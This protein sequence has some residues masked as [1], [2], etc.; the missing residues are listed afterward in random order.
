MSKRSKQLLKE[1][2]DLEFMIV[3][4]ERRSDRRRLRGLFHLAEVRN[5]NNR[6]YPLSELKREIDRLVSNG[7][8]AERRLLGELGH[9]DYTHI[10]LERASHVIT[11]LRMEGNKVFGELEILP[12]PQGKILEA[13]VES[14]VKLGISSRGLGVLNESD[15]AYIVQELELITWDVVDNPSTPKAWLGESKAN[16]LRKNYWKVVSNLFEQV[17]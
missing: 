11:D 5:A 16:D 9:P 3:E 1:R 6:I 12:T 2:W 14:N 10:N 13:L 7:I 4:S 15:G 17:R 8:V